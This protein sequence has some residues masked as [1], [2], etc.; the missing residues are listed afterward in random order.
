MDFEYNVLAG[1]PPY[2]EPALSFSDSGHQMF[3][4]GLVVNFKFTD[5]TSFVGNFERGLSSYDHCIRHPNGRHAI[6]IAGG[7]GYVIDPYARQIISLL[8]SAITDSFPHPSKKAIVL[9]NQ[10][11][12]FTAIGPAGQLWQSRRISWDGFRSIQMIGTML[13]GE[14]WKP[15][16]EGWCAFQLDLETGEVVGGSYPEALTRKL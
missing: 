12:S 13:T 1:L 14:A 7:E 15:Y 2:G 3:S 16:D 8:G 5:G 11:L 6:V 4:E 10:G 9:N